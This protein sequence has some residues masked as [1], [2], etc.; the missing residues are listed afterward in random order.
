MKTVQAVLEKDDIAYEI[1]FEFSEPLPELRI[2]SH[3][4]G[5]A[6]VDVYGLA[7]A[8]QWPERLRYRFTECLPAV[9]GTP[10]DFTAAAGL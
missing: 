7:D 3:I 10:D 8:S 9:I 1:E 5:A 4:G 2:P 6:V